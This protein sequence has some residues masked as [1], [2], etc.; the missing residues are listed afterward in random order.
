MHEE[1]TLVMQIIVH[2]ARVKDSFLDGRTLQQRPQAPLLKG[3]RRTNRLEIE[4]PNLGGKR[5]GAA[6]AATP[7][8]TVAA[9]LVDDEVCGNTIA[10]QIR[11]LHR[12]KHT[13][14]ILQ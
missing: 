5:T 3:C 12:D 8:R 7:R 9:F 10:T 1:T 6:D 11:T 14:P 4:D 2:C 13:T